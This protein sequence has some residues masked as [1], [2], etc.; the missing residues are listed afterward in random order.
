MWMFLAPVI[1]ILCSTIPYLWDA[2]GSQKNTMVV[3]GVIGGSLAAWGSWYPM[4]AVRRWLARA[5]EA[6]IDR[7]AADYPR[8]VE[9]WGGRGVLES[10][11][12][13]AALLRTIDPAAGAG[14]AGFLRRLFGG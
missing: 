9:G 12:S 10:P 4:A 5:R 11:E 6:E 3:F 13:V 8:L 1:G 2:G 14:R 7:F